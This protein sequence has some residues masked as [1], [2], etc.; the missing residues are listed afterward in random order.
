MGIFPSNAASDR[1]HRIM[2]SHRKRTE[3]KASEHIIHKVYH[4]NGNTGYIHTETYSF[5][6]DKRKVKFAKQNYKHRQSHGVVMDVAR[7]IKPKKR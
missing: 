2:A 4:K 3:Y 6:F 7:R 1:F 5:A